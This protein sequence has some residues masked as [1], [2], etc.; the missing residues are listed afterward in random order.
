VGIE[1]YEI[2]IIGG[3]IVGLSTAMALTGR[4]CRS[5]VVVEAE[6][7]LATH[8]S[9][10]NSGVI[11]S[12]L[13][14]T[15]GSEKARNCTAG[16]EELYRFCA[17]HGIP[18][19]RCG[20]IVAAVDD[21]ELPALARLQRTGE[22]NGLVGLRM[23]S[24]EE[25]REREPHVR[26]VAALLVPDTGVVDFAEVT[27]TF[28]MIA[29]ERGARIRTGFDVRRVHHYRNQIVLAGRH[30]E[31]ACRFVINCGGLQADRVA[32]MCGLNPDVQIVPFRGEFHELR[33]ARAHLVKHLIYPVPDPEMP[34]LGVHFTRGIDGRVLAGP[35]AVLAFGRTSYRRGS[36]SLRDSSELLAYAGFW[37]MA[38]NHWRTGLSECYRT[39]NKRAFVRALRRM[40]PDLAADDLRRAVPG[41]RAQ[42][43]GRDGR[44][45]DDF[46]TVHAERMIHVLNAPSPAAT[47]SLLL[48]RQIAEWTA[49]D[50]EL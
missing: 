50:A 33:P 17:E 34:F 30:E 36:I 1:R 29:A 35:N 23:L 39:L 10:R 40:I 48:G 3:G 28:A 13:Y 45:I 37:R 38:R 32:R 21:G 7:A 4:G 19:R 27:R 49:K 42:A 8:Q 5:V 22:A 15:P 26:V 41:I 16:R 25:L 24:P 14:Y 6:N 18:H 20:K 2:G 12:G 43:V 31:V 11:H 9:G 47:A 46:R 44:L